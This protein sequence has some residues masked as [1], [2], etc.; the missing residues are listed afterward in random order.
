MT[1]LTVSKG[2]GSGLDGKVYNRQRLLTIGAG[3]WWGAT[4]PPVWGTYDSS[5]HYEME[6]R[7]LA[8]NDTGK[9][10]IDWTKPKSQYCDDGVFYFVPPSDVVCGAW[11][12]WDIRLYQDGVLKETVTSVGKKWG[13]GLTYIAAGQSNMGAFVYDYETIPTPN[14]YLGIHARAEFKTTEGWYSPLLSL[15]GDGVVTF[16]NNIATSAVNTAQLGLSNPTTTNIPVGLIANN[17]SGLSI[18]PRE[19]DLFGIYYQDLK[20]DFYRQIDEALDGQFVSEGLLW[21]QGE[22]YEELVSWF[23]SAGSIDDERFGE[24]GEYANA[25]K[26]VIKDYRDNIYSP[27][28][29]SGTKL[30]VILFTLPNQFTSYGASRGSV[31]ND[32]MHG[33][34]HIVSGEMALVADTLPRCSVYSLCSLIPSLPAWTTSGSDKIFNGNYGLHIKGGEAK[35]WGTKAASAASS[36]SSLTTPFKKKVGSPY[37]HSAAMDTPN[38]MTVIVKHPN[39]TAIISASSMSGT[40]PYTVTLQE[41]HFLSG[42]FQITI[43]GATGTPD[44]NGVHTA[45]STGPTTFTIAAGGGGVDLSQATVELPASLLAGETQVFEAGDCHGE[46]AVTSVAISKLTDTSYTKLVLTLE[47]DMTNISTAAQNKVIRPD[48]VRGPYAFIKVNAFGTIYSFPVIEDNDAYGGD[49]G[50]RAPVI[51]SKGDSSPMEHVVV[52]RKMHGSLIKA[53][54]TNITGSDITIESPKSGGSDQWV[55]NLVTGA[56]RWPIPGARAIIQ[57]DTAGVKDDTSTFTTTEWVWEGIIRSAQKSG[58]GALDEASQVTVTMTTGVATVAWGSNL[59]P[60]VGDY[61]V[62]RAQAGWGGA[63]VFKA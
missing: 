58:G 21:E 32:C 37:V 17:I 26:N 5:Q 28:T 7:V 6:V 10:A 57:R 3:Q 43:S 11:Y 29:G 60:Q 53:L 18:T 50:W 45:T 46:L 63:L 56:P 1:T 8:D 41:Q 25:L 24:G 35:R 12:Q 31:F 23:P 20:G 40:G 62:W 59:T 33:M 4:V 44:V 52:Q 49:I 61:L 14:A 2:P 9:V 13:V 36:Y 27:D 16:M 19:N 51:Q 48:G 55:F 47:R 42:S 38:Q 15:F 22:N 34:T 30:P 39:S 54:I